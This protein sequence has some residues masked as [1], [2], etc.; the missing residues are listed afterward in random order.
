[1]TPYDRLFS[2][3]AKLT[4]LLTLAVLANAAPAVAQNFGTA[5]AVSGDQILIGDGA[6][7]GFPGK[8]YLFAVDPAVGRGCVA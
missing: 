4:C 8:V 2:T 5:V 1:M 3:A 6:N 7:P